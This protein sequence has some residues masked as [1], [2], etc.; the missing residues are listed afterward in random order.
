MAIQDVKCARC[1]KWLSPAWRD[2]CKHCG[3]PMAVARPALPPMQAGTM[4][5]RPVRVQSVLRGPSE[6]VCLQQAVV[7]GQRAAANGYAPV[8]QTWAGTAT[9]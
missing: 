1:G 5:Q 2:E 6:A 3:A 9:T 4:G 7:D 8:W